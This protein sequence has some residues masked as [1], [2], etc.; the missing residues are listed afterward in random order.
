MIR[1]ALWM[2]AFALSLFLGDALGDKSLSSQAIVSQYLEEPLPE[3][4]SD[5]LGASRID[6]VLAL[7]RVT[8]RPPEEAVAA[9]STALLAEKEVV[10]RV[11][12]L[13][14][15]RRIQT[16]SAAELFTRYVNDPDP[17]VR[18]EA[19]LGLRTLETSFHETG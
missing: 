2:L 1:Y 6:R 7:G 16:R 19:E 14:V 17:K 18:H 9:I 3:E 13:Q 15:L 4:G 8:D 10:H 11:E 5:P 12:L